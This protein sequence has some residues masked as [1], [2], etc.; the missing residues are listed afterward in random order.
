MYSEKKDYYEVLSVSRDCTTDE[1]KQSYRKLAR[2]YHPDVNNGDPAAAERFKEISEAYAVLS[3]EEKRRQ[4]DQFGFSRNLFEN[5]NYDSVF[6]EFGFGDIFDMFFGT[7]FGRGSGSSYSTR[8]RRRHARGS[9]VTA[10]LEVSFK[11]SAFGAKKELEYILD[12]SCEDCGGTGSKSESG[13][14]TCSICRGTGQ[15]RISRETFLGS[16]VTASTCSSCGGTGKIVKEPCLNCKGKG[17][18]RSK[19]KIMVDIPSGI[20]DGD[21]LKVSG[22][23]NSKGEDSINGDLYITVKVKPHPEFKRDGDDVISNINISFAQAALGC[24]LEIETLDGMEGIVIKPGTQPETKIVLK[25]RGIIPLNGY[26]RG[27]HIVNINIKIPTDLTHE[28]I[29]LIK[30]FAEGR[31]EIVGDGTAGF[32]SNIKNAFKK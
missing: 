16:L 21:K 20:H 14:V 10:G 32:F 30:R 18:Y 8:Q 3:N 5:F 19:K 24:R 17:Y 28:E 9:D 23:G 25:S 4:Y 26:R 12:V 27:N 31:E 11:E 22:K 7:S 13:K 1:I 29:T 15:V 6:S 2:K